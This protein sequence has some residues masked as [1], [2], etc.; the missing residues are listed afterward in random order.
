MKAQQ[1]V[2]GKTLTKVKKGALIMRDSK[3][4]KTGLIF[5]LVL[6][7]LCPSRSYAYLDP[8][9]GSYLLQLIIAGLLAASFTVK[10]FWRNIKGFV[11]G[12][13]SRPK[14]D[15]KDAG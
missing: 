9:S 13:F 6:I 7:F 4:L 11:A 2:R 14:K 5:L 15:K 10:S 3:C 1:E 12:L 8:G